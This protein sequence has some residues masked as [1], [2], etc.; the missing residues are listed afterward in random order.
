MLNFIKKLIRKLANPSFDRSR[1]RV[2]EKALFAS[3]ARFYSIS[4]LEK[5]P[6]SED[7]KEEDFIVVKYNNQ[8]Y[9]VLFKCPCGC[10]DIISLSTQKN[11]YPKWN[12][13]SSPSGRPNLYPS[14]RQTK[15]CESHF[16]I[17][18]GRIVWCKKYLT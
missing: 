4:Y 18:D 3:E 6:L 14:V 13:H 8:P 7:L 17:T 11:R 9:W 2:K 12:V 1:Y 5:T 15:G 10:G 16:W